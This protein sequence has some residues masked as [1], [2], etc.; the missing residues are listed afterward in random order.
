MLASTVLDERSGS[1]KRSR[2]S[3]EQIASA[4]RQAESGTSVDDLSRQLGV[5]EVTF[6]T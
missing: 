4:I 1:M 3:K 2:F 5:S 6:Y